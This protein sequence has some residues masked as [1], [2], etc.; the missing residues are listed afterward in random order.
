MKRFLLSAIALVLFGTNA[1]FAQVKLEPLFSDNMVLQQLTEKAPI[2]G[3][4]KPGKKIAIT[5]SWNGQ[6]TVTN[7]DEN[8]HWKTTVKTPSAGGPYTITI[9]DGKKKTILRNVMIGEVWLCSGQSNMEMQVEGWGHV[10]NWE[11]E[12]VEADKYPNIRFLLVKHV[13]NSKPQTV[14]EVENDGWQVCNSQS[15]A[16][17]SACGYFF[18][19]DINKYRNVPVGL[20]DASW[21]GTYVEPWTSAEALAT[22]PGQEANIE[23]VASVPSDKVERKT[24][25]MAKMDEWIKTTNALDPGFSDGKWTWAQPS[26]DDSSWGQ[27]YCP[28][29]VDSQ[30]AELKSFDGFFWL[31]RTVEI[32]KEWAGKD[33]EAHLG[34]IDDNDVTFFNG[35]EI[36]RTNGYSVGRTYV[37]P[38]KLVKAGKAV[39]AVRVHDTGSEAGIWNIE[40]EKMCLT[41]KGTD[42]SL[43]LAGNWAYA[44]AVDASKIP[45][46][47]VDI[48]ENPNE[49]TV[50]FN[51][52]IHPFIPYTIKGAIWYQ[53]EN[54]S[55]HA[56]QYRELMPLMIKDWRNQWGYD[57]PFY[58]VQLA[59]FMARNDQPEESSW[60]EL[61]E[62]QLLTRQHLE[63]VGMATIIDIGEANDIHPKNKQEVGR[64]LALAARATA[65]GE[66][67]VY[68]GPMYQSY[69]IEG[70]TIRLQ[71]ARNTARGMKTSDG[72]KLKGFAIA[73][74]DHKWHW[75]DAEIVKEQHGQWT[76]ESIVVSCP[77]VEFPVAVRYAWAN[78]P[79][80][81]LVNGEG[82]P[83]SPF[84]TDDWP[85]VTFGNKR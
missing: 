83:A 69:K 82:L 84:R 23:R 15:V 26:T 19:R 62:A 66:R 20:I 54:N 40:P 11:Q 9:A 34:S 60:A 50:L 64:R 58:Q 24:D 33:L 71:F 12:K 29:Y 53:G 68:E 56:Y 6:T 1:L 65:Y 5:T 39:I 85:G 55:G 31:R 61:R 70:N 76:S 7:S 41:V 38:G 49:H 37:I 79:E 67:V 48:S 78:N 22:V 13:T 35:T 21:G 2:W 8:G 47:P 14:Q 27:V 75:A 10:K 17:F 46:M 51:A 81:N 36:G 28:Q 25:F 72:G 77:E 30:S 59:N 73:G 44:I 43:P 32:P 4:S 57:F 52:M 18:G 63:N 42:S 16:N 74:L 45:A 80:C 3:E